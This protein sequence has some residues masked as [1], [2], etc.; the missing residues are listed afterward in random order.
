MLTMKDIAELCGVS[1]QTVHAALNDK[2][3][4]SEDTKKK[5]LEVIRENNYTPNRLAT[6]LHKKSTNLVGVTILNIRN[7]FFADLIQ[8]IGSAL[9]SHEQHL[10]FFEVSN[11]EEEIEAIETMMAYQVTGVILSPVQDRTRTSHL[12]AIQKRGLPLI[13]IGPVDG[14][15]THHVEV[16]NREAGAIA[17]NYVIDNG[18]QRFVYLEGPRKI[19]SAHERYLG[20]LQVMVDRGIEYDNDCFVQ[21][22]DRTRDG[23]ESALKIFDRERSDWPSVIVCFNDIV[24]LGVYEAA[25]EIG[26]RIPEE[27]SIMGCDDIEL[28]RVL[29]PPLT[30]VS[31][32]VQEMGQTAA[33]MLV[34]QIDNASQL[35]FLTRRFI[36]E[37]V[38]RRSVLDLSCARV[39][40]SG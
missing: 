2:P 7:P 38:E 11:K 34:S 28:A 10:M 24:A 32:P 19:I 40:E 17:A 3:G 26:I 31:I 6:N 18:H 12:Q 5:I 4:V 15:E 33:E 16:E 9:K 21:S 13:S 29:G 23:Y 27:V 39:A 36:P 22:G 30:T 35:G 25:T 20:F 1:R 14:L 37:L 8:G